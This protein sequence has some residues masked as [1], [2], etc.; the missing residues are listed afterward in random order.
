[1]SKRMIAVVATMAMTAVIA[2]C[3]GTESPTTG[4]GSTTT[5]GS[6]GAGGGGTT[7][8]ATSTSASTTSAT[9]SASGT[10]G[11]M[12]AHPLDEGTYTGT[13]GDITNDTCNGWITTGPLA[14]VDLLWSSATAFTL[15]YDGGALD[16][17][18]D[19]GAGSCMPYVQMVPIAANAVLNVKSAGG[20]VKVVSSTEF[21]F[22]ETF[23]LDCVGSGCAAYAMQAK[24]AFPC[25]A[26]AAEDYSM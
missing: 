3:G 26:T 22:T 18:L 17:T 23:D 2:A 24:T 13:W 10:G 20:P 8:S 9:T 6:G 12:P 4:T 19:N 15:G 11:G 16:C 14:A 21:I 1:M 7:A 5:S 25:S